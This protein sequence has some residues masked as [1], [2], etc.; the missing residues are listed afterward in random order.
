[1]E[2]IGHQTNAM[3][4]R[5]NIMSDADLKRAAELHQ[6]YLHSGVGT[7]LGTIVKFRQKKKG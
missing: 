4:D 5:Y 1:M 6:T 7:T 2:R 3:V